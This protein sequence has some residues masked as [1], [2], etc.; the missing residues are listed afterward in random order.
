MNSPY[1][2]KNKNAI[3]LFIAIRKF[4]PEFTDK[5]LKKET[6]WMNLFPGKEY[7]YGVMKNFIHDLT[8]LSEK[9]ILIEQYTGNS[10]QCEY[11]LIEAANDRNIPKY[12]ST[13]IDQFGKRI[14][15][16]INPDRY[17]NINEFLRF[18]RR[19][20][21]SKSTFIHENNLKE[22]RQDLLRTSSD[23]LLFD[24]LVASFKLINNSIVSKEYETR[25]VGNTLLE[26]FFMKLKEHSILNDLLLSE[27]KEPDIPS[28]IVNCF[29]MMYNAVTSGGDKA[30]YDKFKFY[31]LENIELLSGYELQNL[32]NC[33]NNISLLLNISDEEVARE[34]LEWF[35]YLEKKNIL[36]LRNGLIYDSLMRTVINHSVK[37]KEVRFAEEFLNKY[38]GRLP[39]ESRDNTFNYCMAMIHF[40]KGEF[41]KSLECLAKLRGDKL[42]YKYITKKLYLR[43]YYELND[44]ESFLYALDTFAHFKKRNKL[45]NDAR[46]IAFDEFGR[47]VRSLFRLRNSY[48]KFEA[49]KLRKEAGDQIWFIEKLD[50][51]EKVKG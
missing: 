24:F 31:L 34:T 11:D 10:L 33:R 8:G 19:Y 47:N 9:F 25:T 4:A 23:Y 13:K 26:K 41:G 12:T 32:N 35:K 50:E 16:G 45:T 42:S 40:G 39:A 22:D 30:E 7:N 38:A 15:N 5:D 18:A 46:A 29:Y 48:D 37:L 6:V 17:S 43:I 51:L 21:D 1:F 2:N 27:N 3:R 28:K 44:Y 14:K 36:L 49:A 20:D